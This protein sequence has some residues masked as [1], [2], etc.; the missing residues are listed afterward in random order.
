LRLKWP[1]ESDWQ[2][3]HELWLRLDEFHVHAE[4][5]LSRVEQVYLLLLHAELGKEQ[6]ARLL[7]MKMEV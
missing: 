4:E 2:W 5:E 1:R 6:R 7:V 3:H